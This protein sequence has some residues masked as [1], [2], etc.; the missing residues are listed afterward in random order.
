MPSPALS[1]LMPPWT[2]VSA[3]NSALGL[4][5]ARLLHGSHGSCFLGDFAGGYYDSD[6]INP[7][8]SH[9]HQCDMIDRGSGRLP[10]PPKP[11]ANPGYC[12]VSGRGRA[13]PR[14]TRN[15][16]RRDATVKLDARISINGSTPIAG[17]S[18]SWTILSKRMI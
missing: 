3:W 11:P 1:A 2:K 16:L 13:L 10:S 17:W 18:I 14:V 12:P 9:F 15:Q 7:Y 6:L 4:G 8:K 5:C